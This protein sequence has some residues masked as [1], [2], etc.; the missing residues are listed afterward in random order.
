M[1]VVRKKEVPAVGDEYPNREYWHVTKGIPLALIL[2][3]IGVFIGQTVGG[4]WYISHLDSRVD[5]EEKAQLIT[6]SVIKELQLGSSTQ[7]E[8]MARLEEKV[9]S[10]Q[11]TANRIEALLTSGKR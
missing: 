2:T 11:A 10:V 8:R 5:N 6:T 3:V 4:I 7:G 9:V 1:P